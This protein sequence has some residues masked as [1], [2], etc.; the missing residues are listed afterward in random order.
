MWIHN[1]CSKSELVINLGKKIPW[2]QINL[3]HQGES[4]SISCSVISESVVTPQIVAHQAPLSMEFSR[5]EYWSGLPFLS[6]R[7]CPDSGI[8]LCSPTLQADSL[9]SEPPEKPSHWG[10]CVYLSLGCWCPLKLLAEGSKTVL[11]K[12]FVETWVC[13]AGSSGNWE[14]LLVASVT[15]Q[16]KTFIHRY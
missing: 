8:E 4:K 11:L 13:A 5:Q 3:T 14:Y 6:Q 12:K 16:K 2:Q 10:T 1:H 15:M 7:N 9:L